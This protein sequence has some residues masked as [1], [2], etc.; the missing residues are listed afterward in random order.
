M[1]RGIRLEVNAIVSVPEDRR[2]VLGNWA[3]TSSS[4]GRR[5]NARSASTPSAAM[6]D[7]PA[8]RLAV[9]TAGEEKTRD[10]AQLR[11][12]IARRRTGLSVEA[13]GRSWERSSRLPRDWQGKLNRS[14]GK[15][16]PSEDGREKDDR[17]WPPSHEAG[18]ESK[19]GGC[20]GR[21][22]TA[23]AKRGLG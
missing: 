18:K 12:Q 15:W 13:K 10:A 3:G 6:I 14:A 23:R 16:R 5:T 9:H 20:R 17:N 2:S 1:G 4:A 7:F 19:R 22:V 21:F 8:A 11:E